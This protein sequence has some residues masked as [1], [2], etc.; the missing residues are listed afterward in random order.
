MRIKPIGICEIIYQ[1]RRPCKH[2]RHGVVNGV[3]I[4][5][6][7][8]SIGKLIGVHNENSGKQCCYLG[9]PD[10]SCDNGLQ[11]RFIRFSFPYTHQE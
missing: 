9:L 3:K 1:H 6:I 8:I 2:L 4:E 10:G 5:C 11:S 7:L